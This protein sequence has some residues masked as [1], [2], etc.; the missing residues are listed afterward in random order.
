MAQRGFTVYFETRIDEELYGDAYTRMLLRLG[1]Q[2]L[3]EAVAAVEPAR[4]LAGARPGGQ[5]P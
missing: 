2:K 5:G 1:R 3:D 4:H